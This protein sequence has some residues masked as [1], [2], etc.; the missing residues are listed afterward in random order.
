MK[1]IYKKI[2]ISPFLI[3]IIFIS[4]ISGLFREV[5]SFLTV[6]LIHE[7][8]HVLSSLLFKWKI[9]KIDITLCGGFITYNDV[10]DKPY[11]EEVIVALAG[12][13]FQLLLFAVTYIFGLINIIDPDTMFLINKYNISIFLFNMIPIYPLDISKIISVIFNMMYSYKK[14]LWLINLLSIISI[15]LI[16]ILV[17]YLNIKIEIS[18]ILI[19]VFILKKIF[20]HI[21]D[22]PY[23]FNRLLFERYIYPINTNKYNYIIGK[24]INLFKRRCKNYFY[25]NNHYICERKILSKMFD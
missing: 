16:M 8:G 12:F 19:L 6:I 18:Y 23:L 7:F 15:I 2:R 11:K 9:E 13:L 4:F 25:I 10:I 3:F 20:I 22:I 5:L 1:S 14:A 21:K 24:R 17:F